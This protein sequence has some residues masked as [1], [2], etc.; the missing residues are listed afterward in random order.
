M[1][2][3]T[4]DQIS[5]AIENNNNLI[6]P[7][8]SGF[9]TLDGIVG[10]ECY[11]GGFC[12]VFPIT[13]GN[14]KFA[15]RVWHT[16]IDGIKSR[17]TKIAS[18]LK[19]TNSPYF[20]D[21]EILDQGIL[22]PLYNNDQII[23][24]IKMKWV[25]GKNLSEYLEDLINN[26]GLSLNECK[27]KILNLAEKFIT[28]VK[29]L[30]SLHI[31]HGDLQH[32]NIIID[33]KDNIFLVDYDSVFVPTFNG[34]MQVTTGLPAYQH[35][36]RKTSLKKA[37]VKDDYYSERII[38]VS[39]LALAEDPG[40]WNSLK[41]SDGEKDEHSFILNENDISD[42]KNSVLFNKIKRLPNQQINLIAT[43]IENCSDPETLEPIENI[44]RDKYSEQPDSII[45]DITDWPELEKP[46]KPTYTKT[47][48]IINFDS[49]TAK[50]RYSQN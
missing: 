24:A 9:K 50:Q 2:L 22:V 13:N 11:S 17:L 43:D 12:L 7:S 45:I 16:E 42:L 26:Q 25:E 31:S 29:E 6:D 35:P 32:G 1:P 48:I 4:K 19:S 23:E 47:P 18:F 28:M 15:F 5:K 30:H 33:K 41:N 36:N 40:I 14:E 20:V 38:Y 8:L 46:E 34:E 44:L 37:S 27:T 39:L 10:P 49:K 21:F 3:P